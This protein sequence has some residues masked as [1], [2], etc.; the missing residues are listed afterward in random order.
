[1]AA[2]MR[3]VVVDAPGGPE[4]LRLTRL[5]RPSA[6]PGWVVVEVGGFGVNRS[7]MFTRQGHS[8][9]VKF[10]RVLGIECVGTVVESAEPHLPVGT[11]V[12]A[13][14]GEMG[15]AYDGSYAEY[16]ALP[17]GQVMP[18]RTGLD[19]ATLAAVPETFLTAHGSLRALGLP[20]GA[21]LVS[22]SRP[23]RRGRGSLPTAVR[24]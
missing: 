19:W 8:P 11:V 9:S 14:M 22:R 16:V 2:Q 10:P 21:R 15:R 7:E 24:R 6:R 3:A 20:P 18:V 17:A 1:M 5:P 13:C 4:V 12:A 23:F